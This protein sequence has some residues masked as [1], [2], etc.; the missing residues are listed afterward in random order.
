MYRIYSEKDEVQRTV[1][2]NTSGVLVVWKTLGDRGF[3]R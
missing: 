3:G 2:M 1:G